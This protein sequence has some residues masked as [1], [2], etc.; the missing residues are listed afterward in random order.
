[1]K[2]NQLMHVAFSSGEVEIYHGTRM[3]NLTNLWSVGN[4]SRVEGGKKAANLTLFLSSG[5]TKEFIA[6]IERRTGCKAMEISGKGPHRKTWANIHL[7]I[8]AAEHLS[9]AFHFEVIDTFINNKILSLRDESGDQFKALN[10]SIDHHLP[11]REGKDNKWVYVQV[12]K[13]IKAKATTATDWNHATA[14]DLRE[15]LRIE[16]ALCDLLR[17]GLV[18][19]YAHLRELV[20]KV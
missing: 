20:E 16:N 11:G 6:E 19:D 2:T 12:A 9:T 8:Y 4:V 5:K 1:M 7:M 18:K 10:I 3:G 17:L 13:M 15:R 14:D